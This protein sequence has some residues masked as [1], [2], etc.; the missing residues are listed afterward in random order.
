[1]AKLSEEVRQVWWACPAPQ[2]APEESD[3]ATAGHL[4]HVPLAVG[5]GA[6]PSQ[7]INC[8]FFKEKQ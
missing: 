6:A 1:M 3:E 2:H 5:A 4:S 8:S 7:S